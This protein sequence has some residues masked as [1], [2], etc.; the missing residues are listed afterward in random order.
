[1]KL[2]RVRIA[3]AILSLSEMLVDLANRISANPR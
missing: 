1:M 2:L 3:S